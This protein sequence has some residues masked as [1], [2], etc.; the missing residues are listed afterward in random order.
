MIPKMGV[1]APVPA[2]FS[3]VWVALLCGGESCLPCKGN[4][5]GWQ[6]SLKE[7]GGQLT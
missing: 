1:L 6:V 3:L 2:A 7:L 5:R 4:L